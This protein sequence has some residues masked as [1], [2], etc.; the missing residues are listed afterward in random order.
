MFA[1]ASQLRQLVGYS[2]AKVNANPNVN[3]GVMTTLGLGLAFKR[4]MSLRLGDTF[5]D[6]EADTSSGKIKIHEYFGNG[7]GILFSHP[8]DFTPV[9]TTELGT[10]A[11]LASQGEFAKRNTKVVAVSCDPVD[12]HHGWINDIKAVQGIKGDFPFPI[13]ADPDRKLA[14]R[15]GILDDKER[16]ARG[17]PVTAR[18]VFV[19]GPDKKM[20][21]SILYPATTGRNFNEVLRVLDSLQLTAKYSVATPADWKQGESCMIVPGVSK[22][23]AD[24]K[25]PK[26]YKVVDV[27]S[28]KQ[29]I[30][31]TPQP[32]DK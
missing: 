32:D 19:V 20:K 4:F 28:G 3:V 26:G 15:L 25:F 30:R 8:A 1:R 5:P 11:K 7:W 24:K 18:A 10:V 31:L 17:V 23:D 6:V 12:S 22:E 16:D 21:L 27:P 2:V 13:I 14:V 9:C 29:Y